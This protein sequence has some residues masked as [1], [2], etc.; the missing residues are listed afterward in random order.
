MLTIKLDKLNKIGG[1]GHRW[2]NNVVYHNGHA[3]TTLTTPYFIQ[4]N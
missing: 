1:T 2:N 3:K 4:F